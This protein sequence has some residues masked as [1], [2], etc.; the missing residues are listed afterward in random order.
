MENQN[1]NMENNRKNM[2]PQ[3]RGINTVFLPL[4]LNYI[5]AIIVEFVFCGVVL[6]GVVSNYLYV[7][8]E[9]EVVMEEAETM[10][11][12]ALSDSIDALMTDEVVAS[13][14]ATTIEV[15]EENLALLTICS[16]LATI[17]IFLWM[18][19]RDK[20][21]RAMYDTFSKKNISVLYYGLV[22]V[23]SG[24]LCLTLNNILTLSQLAETSQSYIESSETLYS[25][26]FSLQILAWGII[27]PI[28]EEI[29]F[30]G[31]IFKRLRSYLKPMTAIFWS[32][33][34]FGVYHGNLVQMIYA[35]CC[36][37]AFAWMYEKFGT[38]KA[39]MIAHICANLVSLILTKYELFVWMFENPIR[40]AI[41]TVTSA[42][43]AAS[44]YVLFTNMT[45]EELTADQQ[46]IIS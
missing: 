26:S 35:F 6:F 5:I 9:F 16:A 31:I 42:V 34:L 23:G 2:P 45:R 17:P 22:I 43:I 27:T 3:Y 37:W 4:I 40:M 44:C 8:P 46:E 10:D 14:T 38:I 24:A 11:S 13:L 29:L 20:K 15:V 12:T 41:V 19:H 25:I 18:M 21:K 1:G 32:A 33:L 30:R 7:S 39:P 28:S 36:G